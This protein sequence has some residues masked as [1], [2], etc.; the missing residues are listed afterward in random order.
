LE[1]SLISFLIDRTISHEDQENQLIDGN[2]SVDAHISKLVKKLIAIFLQENEADYKIENELKKAISSFIFDLHNT[3]TLAYNT[4]KKGADFYLIN[5]LR[6][7]ISEIIGN[8]TE[9]QLSSINENYLQTFIDTAI[10]NYNS[11]L[12]EEVNTNESSHTTELNIV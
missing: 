12:Q 2:F 3:L 5:N 11:S 1:N 10:K 6:G 7:L 4:K 8:Q 9:S